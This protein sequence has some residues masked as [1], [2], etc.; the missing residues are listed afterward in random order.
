[1]SFGKSANTMQKINESNITIVV[2]DLGSGVNFVKNILLL[3]DNTDWPLP[4]K[5]NRVDYFFKEIYPDKLKINLT[6]WTKQEYKLRKF[7]SR[8]GVSITD[9]Y[10]DIS[11]EKVANISNKTKIIF[12]TH[13]P[14]VAEK[15][16]TQYPDIKL[17]SVSAHTDFELIWQIK[18]YIDKIG[19]EKLQNFSFDS[20]A[21]TKKEQYILEHGLDEYY[22]FNVLN[23]FDILKD[24]APKYQIGYNIP[25][26]KLL[27]ESLDSVVSDLREY[28]GVNIDYGQAKTVHNRWKSLH[29]PVEEVYNYTWFDQ[30]FKSKKYAATE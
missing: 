21:G 11:T 4:S 8:Y 26:A 27:S 20:D 15:L 9:S 6:T 28:T 10:A 16:K 14:K 3:S 13:W 2:G 17:V 1:M 30:L 12:F 19:I 24:R 5:V 22:K 7:D 25:I 23:M 29:N 18:T